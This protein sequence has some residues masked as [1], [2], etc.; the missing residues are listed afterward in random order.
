MHFKEAPECFELQRDGTRRLGM[1]CYGDPK[2]VEIM[3]RDLE[4]FYEKGIKTPWEH[5]GGH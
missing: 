5:G 2:T 4:D 1:P 3:L